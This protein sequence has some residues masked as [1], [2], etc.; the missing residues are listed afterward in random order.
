MRFTPL[1][2][3]TDKGFYC[4]TADVY[5]DPWRVVPNALI[6]HAHADHA[7]PGMGLYIGHHHTIAIL[8]HRI[9]KS[10]NFQGLEY[11]ETLMKNG[12]RFSFHPAGHVTGSAMI[13]IEYRGEVWLLSGDYKMEDDGFTPFG[14][15][16]KC[17]HFITE[18]TF[19]L[20]I[21]DWAPQETLIHEMT[22]W[23]LSNAGQ[24]LNSII[25]GYSLGKPQRLAHQLRHL[26]L[27]EH[28][29]VHAM[30][31][32][33][34]SAGIPV[35]YHPL[36]TPESVKAFGKPVL[37]IAPPAQPGNT[38]LE[39]FEPLQLANASGWMALRSNRK[40]LNGEKGFAMSDHADWKGLLTAVKASGADHI[41][42]THG[43][44][45]IFARYLRENGYDAKE[46][47]TGYAD[48]TDH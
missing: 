45:D 18:S 22:E 48:E 19:G 6:T 21:F 28:P 30:H 13:R 29:V 47:K 42:V 32:H 3:F 14:D 26:P 46:V 36:A 17:H 12:V 5:I 44:S 43:Y 2:Q 8:K 20:P 15:I 31:E 34:R 24:G 4:E 11:G 27:F 25:T 33:M 35:P 38:W 1:I 37:I 40:R 16:Q 9:A 10:I 7:R 41:Y 39:Q 23:Y